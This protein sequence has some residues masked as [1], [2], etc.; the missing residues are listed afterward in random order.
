MDN[1]LSW[2]FAHENHVYNFVEK[3]GTARVQPLEN[4]QLVMFITSIQW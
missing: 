2:F 4:Y 1:W 3:P